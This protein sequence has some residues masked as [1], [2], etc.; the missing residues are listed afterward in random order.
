MTIVAYGFDSGPMPGPPNTMLG[1]F[2]NVAVG[3]DGSLFGTDG[4]TL[5]QYSASEGD[6]V[7]VVTMATIMPPFTTFPL[8]AVLA[9]VSAEQVYAIGGSSIM[10]YN[11]SGTSPVALTSLPLDET[12]A[13]ITAASDGTMWIL[14]A[15]GNIY[16]Y[17]AATPAWT[18]VTAPS[19]G[20]LQQISVGS[21]TFALALVQSDGTNTLSAWDG[22]TW[23][24][25]SS[26][27]PNPFWTAACPDGSMWV[28]AG[29]LL[30]LTLA[31]GSASQTYELFSPQAIFLAS[32]A[33]KYGCLYVDPGAGAFNL[34][35]AAYGV[36]TQPAV[37]WP[38]WTTNEQAAYNAMTVALGLDDPNG[39]RGE[40][41][42]LNESLSDLIGEINALA[43]PAGINATAWA[44]VVAQVT[45]E[46]RYANGVRNLFTNMAGLN[47]QIGQI[48]S[49]ELTVVLQMVGLPTVSGQQPS[50]LVQTILG[51]IFDK[52]VSAAIGAAPADVQKVI[53]LAKSIYNYASTFVAKQNGGTFSG[54]TLTIACS[55]LAQTLAD[56]V[57]QTAQSSGQTQTT[58][59]TDWGKLQACG[60][61]IE[62]NFW[63]WPP[64]FDYGVLSG[65]GSSIQLNYYQT[66]MPVQWQI[67]Q[68]LTLL[69]AGEPASYPYLSNTPQY[70][71]LFQYELGS[72]LNGIFWWQVCA[73]VGT[74]PQQNTTGPFPADALVE[75]VLN[76]SNPIDFFT[77]QNGWHLPVVQQDGYTAAPASLAFQPWVDSSSPLTG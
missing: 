39:V 5:Y 20:T 60:A 76:L 67:M 68:I 49:D 23:T 62:A 64:S 56:V 16:S 24:P 52:L 41:T 65:I 46:L 10:V 77:G 37:S 45:A 4:Y 33:S 17:D 54:S 69:I 1:T 6:F 18:K 53:G 9:A 61:A 40:Y 15:S 3:A 34:S 35:I 42:N 73:Q 12:A 57:T 31:D 51:A 59:L 22:A 8:A 36:M 2:V 72:D 38:A 27:L 63:Y 71:F 13:S 26:A 75:A 47:L 19:G 43:V 50:T 32:A 58:I 25:V 7:N 21:A 74:Q 55:K 48:Q 66:L 44:D 29:P 14:A 11:G 70:C 28:M 30:S